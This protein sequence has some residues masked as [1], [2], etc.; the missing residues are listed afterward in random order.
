MPTSWSAGP[1]VLLLLLIHVS[2]GLMPIGLP[3]S[4]AVLA[5]NLV[6]CSVDFQMGFSSA[7]VDQTIDLL[8]K[9]D[10]HRPSVL[11]GSF[12]WPQTLAAVVRR[13]KNVQKE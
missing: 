5:K 2:W 7:S 12:I 1:Y 9:Q 10:D 6:L 4:V 13:P 11:Q 3:L 8:Q